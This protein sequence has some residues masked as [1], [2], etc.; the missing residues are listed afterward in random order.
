MKFFNESLEGF[1]SIWSFT[2]F[3]NILIWTNILFPGYSCTLKCNYN[4]KSWKNGIFSN[5]SFC[6]TSEVTRV[7]CTCPCASTRS[8]RNSHC[9]WKLHSRRNF[10]PVTSLERRALSID[11]KKLLMDYCCRAAC[12]KL[13][14]RVLFFLRELFPRARQLALLRPDVRGPKPVIFSSVTDSPGLTWSETY[15]Y[16]GTCDPHSYLSH[17]PWVYVNNYQLA[18]EPARHLGKNK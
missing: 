14:L 8:L 6:L 4:T 5:W 3:P 16:P 18:I 17:L 11:M 10:V 7:N 1:L 12:R 13:Q 15:T 2:H 9:V